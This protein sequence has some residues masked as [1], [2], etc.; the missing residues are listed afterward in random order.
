MTPIQ[1]GIQKTMKQKYITKYTC[2]VYREKRRGNN[3]L[4]CISI[5]VD[6]QYYINL[7]MH[8]KKQDPIRRKTARCLKISYLFPKINSLKLTF[9]EDLLQ[10]TPGPH[11]RTVSSNVPWAKGS[12]LH[13][14]TLGSGGIPGAKTNTTTCTVHVLGLIKY[15]LLN[16]WKS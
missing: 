12:S 3:S 10:V 4:F 9:I 15:V 7:M 11:R 6:V 8:A 2:M 13:I 1:D 5:N 14:F 16:L